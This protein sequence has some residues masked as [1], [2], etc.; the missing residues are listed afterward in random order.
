MPFIGLSL[1]ISIVAI[2][3]VIK[4]GRSQLW[5][6]VLL[7]LPGLGALAYFVVEVMPEVMGGQAGQRAKNSLGKTLSPNR[8]LDDAKREYAISNTVENACNLADCHVEKGD[9]DEACHFYD[10]ALSGLNEHN[11]D[12]LYKYAKARFKLK[13]F[14]ETRELLD[15]C[16]EK[17][18][19]YKNQ[20]AHLLY[21]KTLHS[22]EENDRA[23]EEY[24]TLITYYTGPEP[25]YHYGL[26]LKSLGSASEARNL[27]SSIVDKSSQSPDH[28]RRLHRQWID[29]AR[30]ELKVNP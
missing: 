10:E 9:Y 28:Y 2:V 3:H 22:L 24:E 25:A 29:L 12:I 27:F 14:A 16:I 20:D 8:T 23:A 1:L 6:M 21:A 26:L 13:A 30:K 19:E 4:T 11:P 18:P 7:A 15:R 17:N 5:I